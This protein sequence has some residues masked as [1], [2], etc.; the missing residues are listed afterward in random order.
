MT[1]RP[2][3]LQRHD[4]SGTVA[5]FQQVAAASNGANHMPIKTQAKHQTKMIGRIRMHF[6]LTKSS[7]LE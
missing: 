7:S 2:I 6:A 3:A 1:N 5:Y 4:A